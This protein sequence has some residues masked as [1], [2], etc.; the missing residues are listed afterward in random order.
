MEHR[1]RLREGHKLRR[2]SPIV[3]AA[4]LCVAAV[5]C[6]R[7]ARQASDYKDSVP[8]PAEPMIRQ[9]ATV[10]RYGGRFVLA[11]LGN[12][13]TF[14]D[15]MSTETSSS[16]I[17]I[18]LF[19]TLVDYNN[20]T[21]QFEP[22][23]AKSW[24]TSPDGAV[25]TFRLRK[26]AGF[27]DGH[28]ITAEDVLFSF[29]IAYDLTLHPAIQD[30][31]K[32][33]G[34]KFDVSAPDPYTV[35]INTWKPDSVLLAALCTGGLTIM[36]KHVLEPALKDGTFASVYNTNTPVDKLVTSG[37]WRVAQYVPGE[38][39]VLSRNPYYFGF[40]QAGHRLPY[41]NELVFLIVPDQDAADLKFRGGEVHAVEDTK[42]ENYRWYEDHQKEANFTLYSL[43]PETN[44]NFFWFNL[45]KA[46]PPLPGEKPTPGMRVGDAYVGPVKYEWFNNPVFRRA[47]SMAIDRDAMIPSVFF[48]H[49]VKSWSTASPGNKVWYTP[50]LIHDD[51]NPAE[52]K[53]L[54][55]SLGWKDR[56]G[57]GVLED[58][59]GNPI[60]F[61]MKTNSSNALRIGMANF[62]KDDLAKVGIK[63]AL[64]PV[65]FNTVIS[66]LRSDFQYDAIL[67]GLQSGVPPTPANGQNVWR[68]SGETHQWFIK[69]QKPAT[70]QEA[71]IDQLLDEILTNLDLDAEKR[72][73]KE[74]QEIVN[75]QAWIVW[76]PIRDYKLP[77]SNKFGN[78][79]P[80]VLAHRVLWN[81]D[82]VFM[83]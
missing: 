44:S 39:T 57:D 54:L 64:V 58:T 69:Q 77:I 2:N 5:G 81:I 43:G 45:N 23:L 17:T 56:N 65:E 1:S 80:S 9:V 61:T 38:K 83:K 16:D 22:A 74:I 3:A 47:V 33:D 52:S 66:N 30:L 26:G 7:S 62:I 68:S 37:P 75:Q 10:G 13:K 71:R 28:P 51:Y 50:N 15:L 24:E 49:G 70:P 11:Q 31:L 76:L 4:L 72:A 35:V 46:Q 42:P 48:G 14:N 55:A 78:L 36:P 6:G 32:M 19:T 27:S 67:L 18:R 40:D 82:R 59:H 79:E 21:Q 12:P 41:L 34:K 73:W 53:R 29:A 8:P 25:W 63:M 60:S 20:G